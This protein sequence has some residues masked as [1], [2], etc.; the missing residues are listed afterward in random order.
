[1]RLEGKA[2]SS[3]AQHSGHH[4][5]S[6][7]SHHPFGEQMCLSHVNGPTWSC[8]DEAEQ[9]QPTGEVPGSLSGQMLPPPKLESPWGGQCQALGHL[10][11]PLAWSRTLR[12]GK[13]LQHEQ[14]RTCK[15]LWCCVQH[16]PCHPGTI[17]ATRSGAAGCR[18]P[19][20]A[21]S[22]R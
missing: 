12:A 15:A 3:S 20:K 17:P 21:R 10:P 4:R 19:Y 16:P 7:E 2:A 9:T 18:S 13:A 22:Q 6:R 8:G 14:H 11:T 1:M 5:A